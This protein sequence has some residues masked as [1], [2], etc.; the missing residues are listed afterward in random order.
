MIGTE[1]KPRGSGTACQPIKASSSAANGN[2]STIRWV[3][4]SIRYYIH[5]GN[6]GRLY[7]H[8]ALVDRGAN[9]GIT[10][11]D[12][13]QLD[14][15]LR[16]ID[17]S[18]L[19][20]H[21]VNKLRLA[22]SV[23]LV[24]STEGKCIGHWFQ[25]AH[26]PNGKSI[27]STLQME[28]YG[29]TVNDKAALITNEHPYI[30]SPC[31]KV[32]P[33]S[34]RQGLMYLDIKP[35]T[36]SDMEKYPH[37]YFTADSDWDPSKYDREVDKSFLEKTK[38]GD[39][40]EEKPTYLPDAQGVLS[41]AERTLTTTDVLSDEDS[42]GSNAVT[43]QEVE[44][45]LVD[46]IKDELVESV[47]EYDVNG[48]YFHQFVEESDD[49]SYWGDWET[50]QVNQ[51]SC[52]VGTRRSNRKRN[53][54]SYSDVQRRNP[55]AEPLPEKES[56]QPNDDKA[57][58][59][60]LPPLP[61]DIIQLEDV[62]D[63]PVRTDYNNPA[64]STLQNEPRVMG[65]YLGKPSKEHYSEYARYLGGVPEKVIEKTFKNTTQLG[66][67]AAIEGANLWKRF[68]APNPALNIMR[69]NEDV[70]TDT[71][72]GP[73]PDIYT[74]ST[75]AQFF[76]GR[77]SGF[78]AVE[79]LGKSD[80]LFHE[81]LKKH[82]RRYGAMDTL[83]SDN[84][85]AQ[86]SRK[87]EEILGTLG[88]NNRTSEPYNKNQ[89]FAERGIRDI[90]RM[91]QSL[92]NTSGAPDNC[93]L[94]AFDYA[95]YVINHLASER[96]DW[97]TPFEWITGRTA[98]LTALLAFVFFEPV[99]YRTF[100]NP[101]D[102]EEKLGRF[103]GIAESVGHALTFKILTE[104]NKIVA[105]SL[106]RKATKGGVFDNQKAKAKASNIA[107]SKP[108]VRIQVGE[109]TA[110]VVVETVEG[111]DETKIPDEDAEDLFPSKHE[112][113]HVPQDDDDEDD[114][115]E[116]PTLTIPTP[117]SSGNPK[118]STTIELRTAAEEFMKQGGN[119]PYFKSDDLLGR[120]F[121]SNP[122]ENQEQRRASIIGVELL[123]QRTADEAQPL[124]RF[125]CRSK[126]NTFEEVITYNKM[127]DW[128]ERDSQKKGHYKLDA[129]LDHRVNKKSAGGHDVKILWA[130]GE[131]TWIALSL[132]FADDPITM[133]WYAKKHNLLDTPGW[134]RCKR[135]IRNEKTIARA[136]NQ[137]RYRNNRL[138]P[139]YKFGYRVPRNREEA[140][141]I[142]E[143]E[144]NDKW[145]DADALEVDQ[146][147]DYKT[148]ESLGKG[149]AIPE[150][151]TLIPYH[152][153]RD[154][155]QTG[156]HK[157]RLVA[158]GHRTSTPV[159]STYSG[160]VSLQGIRLVTFLAELNGLELWG[161]D[162]GNAYLESYT[163]EK[164]CI[165][166]G[167]EFGPEWEG[168]TCIIRK[169]LYGL[170]SSG[171]CWH[172]RLHDVLTDMGFFPSRAEEDIWMRDAGD[173][174]EY[175]AVYVDD[176][177][178][179][180]KDPQSIIKS[181]TDKPNNF[182]LKGTG[183][184]TY[185]LGC[186]FFRD[187]DGTLCMAPK[188]Y[189]ERMVAQYTKLFGQAPSQRVQSPLEKNDHPEL[190]DT[191]LLDEDDTAK[192]Q[193]L[194]GVL[195][196]TISLGRFDIATAVM[197]M[198]SFRAMPRVG[199]LERVKRICGY[200]AK[201]KEACIRVRTGMPD[202]SDLP[203]KEYDWAK[204][205]YGKVRE[206]IPTDAPPPKGKK[207]VSTTYKDANLYHD[208]ATGKAVTGV[209]HFLNQT[210]IEWYSKKQ[211]TVETATYGSEFSA[212][213]T[214]I[215]QIAGLRLT[216]RYLGVPIGECSYLF[217]D[218]ESVVTSSTVPHSQ[219]SKRW[220]ALSY[221]YTR[222]AIASGMVEFH[223]IPG[224]Q[225]PADILSKHWGHSQVYP[226]LRPILF[227][228][229]DTSDLL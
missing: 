50:N 48:T 114:N 155:K 78:V 124:F 8:A 115:E 172:D 102:K 59:K 108:N 191:E 25:M 122:D 140:M 67:L 82:I 197:T 74:G 128:I 35:P 193:S 129:V 4:N 213:R 16:T 113:E 170:K 214:A 177:L 145:K 151:Y 38:G 166:A 101:Q 112:P 43:R 24:R 32:F 200:L 217:G 183:P 131:K 153:V 13:R 222:E 135:F 66:R 119:M 118:R 185:H 93:W 98:D 144:G 104:D 157:S 161:T 73:C 1:T 89:N 206:S 18:G 27:L 201:F 83:I 143:Q 173:H 116:L 63:E 186:D 168:H 127:L 60:E 176:L 33:L 80:A 194:I 165:I 138:K 117:K 20:D 187:D 79:P 2:K 152:I 72:Y 70:A 171:K 37:V 29:C 182:K 17:L 95:C 11:R 134:K 202:Y 6:L 178:I 181:L 81:A 162:I 39:L 44:V 188:K 174:Y 52:F 99:F 204:T 91:V 54:V 96:L 23:A 167:P 215:Q 141:E 154:I 31:G 92:M 147:L 195:Q 75:A 15:A 69:R 41:D 219:L 156:R 137:V 106:V 9:G 139:V 87:I 120:T 160:V 216:L 198:S 148:L 221:H 132:L 64:K 146:I 56:I 62:T 189:I 163:S 55:K 88:I 121:I 227:Y 192:Y 125:K 190:D 218:N 130:N 71:I 196:W 136:V 207:V 164:V 40:D 45:N 85:K 90:K 77:K 210:P 226:L 22:H 179:A 47:I 36:D 123:Q 228:R 19:D 107:P 209:L 76:I 42:I 205:T 28:A 30:K 184:V 223:H 111:E 26:M 149:A 211:A 169:A 103:V 46:A 180:S 97:R 199:H 68:K 5:N 220:H 3:Y 49:D 150:G 110:E 61:D 126:G 14:F 51:R 175:I 7:I 159:D 100:D 12:M 212:A 10:G 65:P 53:P 133:A 86:I 109:E 21:T 229:G 224:P 94:L 208:L 158:G 58:G 105:R 225:N 142:D 34:T 203:R 57:T 84:A